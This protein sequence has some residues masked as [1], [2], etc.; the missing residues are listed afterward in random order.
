VE[1]Q[2]HRAGERHYGKSTNRLKKRFRGA[3]PRFFK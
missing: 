2:T 1:H 3:T